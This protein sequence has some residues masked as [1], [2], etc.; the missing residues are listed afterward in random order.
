MDKSYVINGI[1]QVGIGNRKVYE[2]YEWYKENL[3]MKVQVFDEAAEAKLMLPYTGGQPRSRHAI[4]ALNLNGGGGIEVWQYVDRVAVAPKFHIQIG[5]LGI[6]AIQYKCQDLRKAHKLFANNI[7]TSSIFKNAA[8]QAH[9]YTKDQDGNWIDVVEYDSWFS[10]KYGNY[11]GVTGAVIGVSDL[12]KSIAFYRDILGYDKVIYQGEGHFEDLQQMQLN[13]A[14][15]DEIYERALLTHSDTKKGA[16][17][18]LFGQTQIELVKRN[19]YD[20]KK[21]FQD[22]L[23]GDMGYI[24]LCFD[25][26]HMNKLSEYCESKGHPFQVDSGPF[27]MGEAGGHFA[28]IEDP[29]GTL[30]EF[31]ETH[32][33]PIVKK[34]NWYLDLQKRKKIKPLPDWMIKAM[35]W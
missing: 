12:E 10:K 18:R 11:G 34:L 20:A 9:F 27:G 24:H 8:G 5:D 17:S 3:G 19:N 6:L 22:R 28:Y 7:A 16:F 13:T 35:G 21:I 15:G 26:N 33:V 23:W 2:T 32:K 25:V 31:V 4:L 14:K 1:Q 29:D 30:I